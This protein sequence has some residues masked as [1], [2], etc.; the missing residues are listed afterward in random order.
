M[1]EEH[2]LIIVLTGRVA[3][4]HANVFKQVGNYRHFICGY[5]DI[6]FSWADTK[7]SSWLPSR[8]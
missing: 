3:N 8:H 6:D 4:I 5:D 7:R 2:T 1:G